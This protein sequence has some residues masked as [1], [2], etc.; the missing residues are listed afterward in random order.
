MSTTKMFCL[1]LTEANHDENKFFTLGG[2]GFLSEAERQASIDRI[3]AATDLTGHD[4]QD[5]EVHHCYLIDVLADNGDHLDNFEI[6]EATAYDVLGVDDF[7]PMRQ[8]ERDL[9]ARV[10]AEVTP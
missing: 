7:E 9:F 6:D 2:A 1:Q 4:C 5:P 10:L 3:K 8:L